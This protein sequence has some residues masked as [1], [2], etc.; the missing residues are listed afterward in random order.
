MLKKTAS[1]VLLARTPPRTD[2]VRLGVL[3]SCGLAGPG[4]AQASGLFEHP[5]SLK[6]NE[7]SC[8][9]R[10]SFNL[11]FSKLG[12]GFDFLHENFEMVLFRV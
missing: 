9:L 6:G 2:L 3:A 8:C 10:V 7:I 1:G 12:L 5:V 11:G 4:F